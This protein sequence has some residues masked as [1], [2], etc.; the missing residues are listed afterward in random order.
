[1]QHFLRG[2]Y[3]V[4]PK[5]SCQFLSWRNAEVRAMGEAE[6]NIEVLKKYSDDNSG[7]PANTMKWFWEVL[8]EMEEEDK[9]KYLKFVNSRSKMPTN[10]ALGRRHTINP[11]RGGD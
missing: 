8:T 11:G 2:V 9:Q 5:Q 3:F 7:N 6:I 1:M 4:I 10:P